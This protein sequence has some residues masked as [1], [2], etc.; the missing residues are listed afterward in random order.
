MIALGCILYVSQMT[1]GVAVKS[2]N[3]SGSFDSLFDFVDIVS[4][5]IL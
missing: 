5:H 3:K 4:W 2:V 1:H